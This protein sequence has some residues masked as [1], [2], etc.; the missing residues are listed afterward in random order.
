MKSTDPFATLA[1][2][3]DD[4]LLGRQDDLVR[5][6]TRV[7]HRANTPVPSFARRAVLFA[8]AALL[9]FGAGMFIATR[10]ANSE[11]PPVRASSQPSH[12][13]VASA[14]APKNMSFSDGS[15]IALEAA[16]IAR[17]LQTAPQE[18]QVVLEQGAANVHVTHAEDTHWLL[19]AGPYHVVVTGTEFLL[20]WDP[21]GKIFSLELYRGAVRVT[22]P[23]LKEGKNVEAGQ[24]VEAHL[25]QERIEITS[26][27]ARPDEPRK[28]AASSARGSVREKQRPRSSASPAPPEESSWQLLCRSGQFEAVVSQ[29]KQRGLHPTMGDASSSDLMALGEAARLTHNPIIAQDV[30]QSVRTRF[31]GT[32]QSSTAA[33]HLGRMAFDQHRAYGLAARWLEIYLQENSGGSFAREALG[34]L[35]EAH[36]KTGNR[37]AAQTCA[38]SYLEKYPDGAHASVA[39]KTL[40][41]N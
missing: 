17:V 20:T 25:T 35:M 26:M 29:A 8:A 14:D 12:W 34:K 33:F 40:K 31:P 4:D 15:T 11:N 9:L 1:R 22:G 5:L 10:Y 27:L 16:S 2:M 18:V 6:R 21:G 7:L 38:R 19:E 39:E 28:A 24:R 23:L 37:K 41:E 30:Y 36:L 3:Q 13:L 32:A